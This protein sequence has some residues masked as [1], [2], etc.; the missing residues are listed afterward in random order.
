MERFSLYLHQLQFC[1][2]IRLN[3]FEFADISDT[4]LDLI[5]MGLE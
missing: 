5:W 2:L 4:S 3:I 1:Q